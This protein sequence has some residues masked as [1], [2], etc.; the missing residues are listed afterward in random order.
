MS[1]GGATLLSRWRTSDRRTSLLIFGC[2]GI[3]SAT[4]P[5]TQASASP[6]AAPTTAPPSESSRCSGGSSRR[7]PRIVRAEERREEPEGRHADERAAEAGER[8]VAGVRAAG[9]E[10]RRGARADD[11]ADDDAGERERRHDEAPS[12]PAQRREGDD[13]QD[14][15]VE[16]G[17][18]ALLRRRQ[19][20]PYLCRAQ[21]SCR[22]IVA[23]VPS[24]P[25]STVSQPS[26]L[27]ADQRHLEEAVVPPG[28]GHGTAARR[29]HADRAAL[30][31]QPSCCTPSAR[32]RRSSCRPRAHRAEVGWET[33][34][35]ADSFPVVSVVV[36]T[37]FFVAPQP[38]SNAASDTNAH[39]SQ[40]P[41]I[42]ERWYAHR[43]STRSRRLRAATLP[44]A[45]G[46][47]SAG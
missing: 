39:A 30:P 21:F 43:A 2:P 5:A 22:P 20:L 40:R 10:M 37:T 38:A 47:S 32:S 26:G 8:R 44:S 11:R 17:D 41:L 16:S 4:A 3:C 24:G 28:L 6:Q 7:P 33:V 18:V 31:E 27:R 46:R 23:G 42:C 15:P 45:W 13:A 29:D 12:E 14:D 36:A 25:R 1:W 19:T 35:A 34:V 9:E